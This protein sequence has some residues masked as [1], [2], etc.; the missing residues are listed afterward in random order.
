METVTVTMSLASTHMVR[1]LIM[2][3]ILRLENLGVTFKPF[4]E[5]EL[6]SARYALKAMEA[7]VWTK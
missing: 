4:F 2:K 5:E 1:L 3:E 7:G 6:A